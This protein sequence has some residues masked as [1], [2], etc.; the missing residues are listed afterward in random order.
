MLAGMLL[1]RLQVAAG[2]AAA[3]VSPR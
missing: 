1:H 3:P 2:D